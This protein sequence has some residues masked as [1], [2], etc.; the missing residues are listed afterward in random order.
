MRARPRMALIGATAGAMGLVLIW[1]L[2]FH[3]HV[4]AQAD[5]TVFVG[6]ADLQRPRVNW[7][8]GL[9]AGICDPAPFLV[10]SLIVAAIAYARGRARLALAVGAILLGANLTTEL[11]KPLL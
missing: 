7:L 2:A 3:T 8:A 10:L 5:R 11:L 6:F 4:G 9:I 1:L